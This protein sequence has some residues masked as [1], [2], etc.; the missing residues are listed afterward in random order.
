MIDRDADI[1]S[2]VICLQ[3]KSEELELHIGTEE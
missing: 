1:Y 3:D 2:G